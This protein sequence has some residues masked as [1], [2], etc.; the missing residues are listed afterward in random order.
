[1]PEG[2]RGK[3][4]GLVLSVGFYACFFFFVVGYLLRMV[5][6]VHQTPQW[7]SPGK[8]LTLSILL[9]ALIDILLLR[10]LLRVND[11]LWLG[12]WTFHAS[13]VILFFRHLRY[14]L[15]PA[16]AF[17][18][19]MEIPARV[20]AWVLPASLLYIGALKLVIEKKPYIS[21]YN[22]ML[23]GLMMISCVSGLVMKYSFPADL[24]DIKHFTMGLVTFHA[25]ISP[26]SLTFLFH[27]FIFLIILMSLPTHIFAAPLTMIEARQREDELPYLMHEK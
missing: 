8:A 20:A 4:V 21:S 26:G 2:W 13:L 5:T 19:A 24:A 3:P 7:V 17:V 11:V 18:A 12:E 1:V 16:P 10:R 14:F 22:F 15:E 6:W 27:F 9:N 25:G 23:L